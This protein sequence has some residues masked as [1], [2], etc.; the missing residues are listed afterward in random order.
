MTQGNTYEDHTRL[1]ALPPHRDR[2][3]RDERQFAEVVGV[4]FLRTPL[5]GGA[6]ETMTRLPALA[7]AGGGRSTSS[8]SFQQSF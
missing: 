1:P 2:R 4:P 5:V 8:L 7:A 6:S 3:G